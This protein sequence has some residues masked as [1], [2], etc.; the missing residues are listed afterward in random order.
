MK[1]ENNETE[2]AIKSS[3]KPEMGPLK[4][5]IKQTN[6]WQG[7]WEWDGEGGH[8]QKKVWRWKKNI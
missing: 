2:N 8:T 1:A 7:W 5:L 6:F 4:W 3:I